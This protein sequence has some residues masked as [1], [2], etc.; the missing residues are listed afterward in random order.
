M[1][2]VAKKS[3]EEIGFTETIVAATSSYFVIIGIALLYLI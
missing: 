3:K 1:A 2:A